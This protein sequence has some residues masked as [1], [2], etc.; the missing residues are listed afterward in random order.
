[1]NK[2]MVKG[3]KALKFMVFNPREFIARLKLNLYPLFFKAQSGKVLLNGICFQIDLDYDVVMRN[4][5]YG[6]YES[7]ISSLLKK[8]L[9]EGDV[10]IDAG[11]NIG[12]MSA[13]ALG[14]VGKTGE[15]HSF[16]PVPRY[17]KRLERIK[18]DNPEYNIFANNTALGEKEET[19]S[20]KVTN[21]RNIGWNTM[22]PDFMDES[23][24]KEEIPV[25]VMRLDEYIFSKEIENVRLIKID[26]E[27]YEFPVLKGLNKYLSGA[28]Q[29]P[30]IIAEIVPD[31]YPRLNS[32]LHE[33]SKY[34]RR[35]R[36]QA[37][38][39]DSRR[40]IEITSLAITTD[41]VF[42]PEFVNDSSKN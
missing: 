40:E 7:V 5:Y 12:Y 18:E 3:K 33:F 39:V 23:A 6:L 11:A 24:V 30:I 19:L 16:E 1:M 34:M 4:M 13:F 10:F 28:K 31:S 22:V 20:I 21:V 42:L 15:V 41:V 36:Y 32:T 29:L 26:V 8:Y 17:F 35:F 38:S 14:M 37:Y 2:L 27:G 25:S 9:R